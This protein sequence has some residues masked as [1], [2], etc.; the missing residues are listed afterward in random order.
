[1]IASYKHNFIFIRTRKTGSTALVIGLSTICGPNDII[2][3]LEPGQER[4]RVAANSCARNFSKDKTIEIEFVEAVRAG[5]MRTAAAL[6]AR[7][8]AT[9]GCTGHMRIA[10]VRDWVSPALW[11]SAFKFA[12]ER[13]PY[14]KAVSLAFARYNAERDGE[15]A[16]HL[17][18]TVKQDFGIYRSF[19]LYMIEGK[20]VMDAFLRHDRLEEDLAHLRRRLSLPHFDLPRARSGKRTESRPAHEI[21]SQDQK[22]FIYAKCGMEF[23]LFGWPR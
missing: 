3:P 21:L 7:N 13:H 10:A 8:R 6:G 9:G 18:R 16:A 22:N 14:E 5:D 1:M 19:R 2:S 17:E 15:F 11:T 20:P 4:L 12:T 23:D